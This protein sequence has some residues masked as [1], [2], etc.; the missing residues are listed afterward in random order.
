MPR[1]TP[2]QLA[3]GSATVVLSTTAMLLLSEARS[4]PAVALVAVVALALGT[5]VALTAP[6]PRRTPARV[7]SVEAVLTM[8]G[9][10]P[11][12]GARAREHSLHR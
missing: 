4:G 7:P 12:A 11:E 6:S 1:P 10:G 5:L 8:T 2:A 9:G 3:Y